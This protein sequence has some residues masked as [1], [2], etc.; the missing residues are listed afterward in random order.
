MRK[1]AVA[2]GM[3]VKG[4]ATDVFPRRKKKARDRLR[5]TYTTGALR[6]EGPR[7]VVLPGVGQ[8]R[9]PESIR[10]VWRHIR[11]GSSCGAPR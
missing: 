7:V 2:A 5:C 10:A 3:I 8:V 6:V 1:F 9:T 11:R 4:R